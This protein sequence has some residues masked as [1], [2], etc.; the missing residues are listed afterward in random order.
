M[1]RPN[2]LTFARLVLGGGGRQGQKLPEF[3]EDSRAD[4]LENFTSDFKLFL[5]ITTRIL[6]CTRVKLGEIEQFGPVQSFL[7]VVMVVT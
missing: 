7:D 1:R 5:V 2:K 3:A 4:A 6:L